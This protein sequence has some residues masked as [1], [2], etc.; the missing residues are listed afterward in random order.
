MGLCGGIIQLP[1]SL[2]VALVR[3]KADCRV[4]GPAGV[5]SYHDWLAG[6]TTFDTEDRVEWFDL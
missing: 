2:R 1:G 3:G 6:A 5:C 4:D